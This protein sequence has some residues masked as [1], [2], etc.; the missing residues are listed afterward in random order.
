MLL[1]LAEV[2]NPIN[3]LSKC[4]QTSTLVYASI[5]AKVNNLIEKLHTIKDSLSDPQVA[6]SKLKFFNWAVS[7]LHISGQ[8]NHLG[9]ELRG[10]DKASQQEPSALIKK[11]LAEIGYS[12]V[13]DLISEIKEALVVDN[14]ILEA[15]NIF[16]IE[17]Q[18]EEY[19]REHMHI[20]CNHYGDQIN[21]IYQGDSTP[22]EVIISALEQKVEFQDFFCTFDEVVKELNDQ[23]KKSAQ[24]KVLKGEIKQKD[25]PEY[26]TTI[27]PTL[28]N[29]YSKMC[30]ECSVHN[31]PNNMK[32]LKFALLIPPSTS[33]IKRGFS[34]MNLLVSPL[35]KS[36]SENNI[37]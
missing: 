24:Q 16:S 13:D 14:P 17:T 23:A 3:I 31:F 11:F 29:V 25:I 7:F 30:S 33:G 22:A 36:L 26:L 18:S 20:L 4:L 28:S 27:K 6:D 19:S 15:F 1:L 2:L 34:I 32:L 5:T 12:F 35:R 21:D 37:D 8:R 9:R 10:R